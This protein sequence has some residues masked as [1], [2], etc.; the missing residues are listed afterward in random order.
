MAKPVPPERVLAEWTERDLTA[1]AAKGELPPTFEMD[2]AL[3]LASDTLASGR[4]LLLAGESGIGKTALVCALVRRAA[5]GDG[6]AVLA[7][8]SVLQFSF[9]HRNAML[10][11]QEELRPEMQRL[12]EALCEMN[13]RIVPF[14]RDFHLAYSFDLEPQMQA[15]AFRL[16]APVIGEASNPSMLSALFEYM[17]ELEQHYVTL[18]L[19]EP[20][21]SRSRAILAGWAA[22]AARRGQQFSDAALDEALHLSHRFLARNRQPRKALDLLVQV[23]SLTPQRAIEGRDV[24][25]RFS[26]VHH[27]PRE[28]I[29]PAVPL[30]LAT[31]TRQLAH[32]LL[33]QEEAIATIARTIALIKAGLA[34][35][36]RPFGVFLFVGPTG[37]GKTHAAQLLAQYLFGSRER[38]VR[39]NMADHQRD[40]SPEVLFG[41]PY[42]DS[43]THRRGLLTRQLAGHPFTVLLLD[44]FEKAHPKVTDRFLQLFDEG[45]FINGNAETL[46]CRSTIVIATSNVGAELHR[47]HP[48]GFPTAA[49]SSSAD[50]RRLA[51]DLERRLTQRFRVEML[52]RFDQ[53]VHFQPLS[54]ADVRHIAARELHAMTER[55][56]FKR[57]GLRFEIDDSVLDW[58]AVHGYDPNFGARFLRRTLEREVTSALANLLVRGKATDSARAILTVRRN[59]IEATL[60][61]DEIPGRAR[62]AVTVPFGTT[63]DTRTHDR[64]AVEQMARDLLGEAV[65]LREGFDARRDEAQ[66]LLAA[67]NAPGFW[68]SGAD[69][70]D[71]LERYRGLDVT[72][73]VEARFAST[74]QELETLLA[75]AAGVRDLPRLARHVEAAAHALRQWQDRVFAE[76]AADV[77]LSIERT[78][79]LQPD[80]VAAWL[81]ELA[82]MEIAWCRRLHFEASAVAAAYHDG[83]LTRIVLHVEGPGAAAYLAVEEGVHR[84][85]RKTGAPMKATIA[86]VPRQE[87]TSPPQPIAT[88][89]VKEREGPAG[90]S[91][92]YAGRI[93]RAGSGLTIE[94]LGSD[95][96]TLAALLTDLDA[97]RDADPAHRSTVSRVYEQDGVGARDPRTGATVLRLKDALKGDLDPFLEAWRRVTPATAAPESPAV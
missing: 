21:L 45:A 48:L 51:H 5:Q 70:R 68:E 25:E 52:N 63:T 80:S 44:E 73:Q 91:L 10:R 66:R 29:D 17:P 79:P 12:V 32:E 75:E 35:A 78:D 23:A 93:A 26:T 8:R 94:L 20:S 74:L 42:G 46:S 56:G 86:I 92:A 30:D 43:L 24:I 60:A 90:L 89:K 64:E 38:L 18:T 81:I 28:L 71:T 3:A 72:I 49:G 82:Q 67:I 11:K 39:L 50:R 55:I 69:A 77:W 14:F 19:E 27:V 95:A 31:V 6:P 83:D 62:A 57:S 16:S 84:R 41:N 88:T 85:V 87:D 34:D 7:G 15:L 96:Y 59:R 33:G 58:L 13:G 2:E 40:D 4:S 9:R 53:I 54:R 47:G 97:C 65:A 61:A 76:G 37:V 36:R 22:D 1:A